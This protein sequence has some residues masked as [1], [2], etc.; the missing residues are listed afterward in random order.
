MTVVPDT[1]AV[2]DGRVS[3]RVESG[4]YEGAAIAVPEA[5]VTELESQAN[6]GRESGW[7]G[8]EELQRLA[9]LANEGAVEVEYVGRRPGDGER[10]AAEEG[11]VDALI[12]D[13]AAK[14]RATLLTSDK[15]QSEVAQ[16]KGLDVEYVGPEIRGDA[17]E[18][19]AIEDFF[20]GETMS[21]HLK[22]G[23]APMAKRG[24]VGEM[25]FETIGD[26]SLTEDDLHEWIGE[27][28]TATRASSD[29]FTELDRDGMTIVQF[30]EYR[31]ALAQPPFADGLEITAVRPIVETELDDYDY[32]DDLRDR[33]LD[34]Q[35]GV[36]I[37]GAPGAGKSTLAGAVAGFLADSAFSVKTMEKPRDLQVGPEITQYTELDGRME[38]AAD[39]L[40][41]VRPDYTVYDEVRKTE[42]FSVLRTSS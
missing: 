11:A 7:D 17:P 6:D 9:E 19:L 34:H 35:R 2:I 20:D 24:A 23:V 12:R 29:G 32:A 18:R 5:V 42:D 21:V 31:I 10:H 36:L 40:L 1:S 37:A 14:E 3:E 27:I 22:T 16:A 28:E 30:G 26:E 25:R 13:L 15:V 33:L 38:N 39:S 41:M 8:L 4:S